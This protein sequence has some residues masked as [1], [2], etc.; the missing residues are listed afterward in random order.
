ME[1]SAKIYEEIY[2]N[3]SNNFNKNDLRDKIDD[4]YVWLYDLYLHKIHNEIKA[5]EFAN[6]VILE[7]YKQQIIDKTTLQIYAVSVL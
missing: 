4:I 3:K 2:N 6:K 1:I 5:K 7:K